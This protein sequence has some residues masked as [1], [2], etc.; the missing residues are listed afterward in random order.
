MKTVSDSGDNITLMYSESE[1]KHYIEKAN[2]NYSD[3]H[4]NLYVCK[5]YFKVKDS[6][7]DDAFKISVTKG[8]GEIIGVN[9][10]SILLGVYFYLYRLGFRFPAPDKSFDLIPVIDDFEKLSLN[11]EHYYPYRHRGICIE[12]AS[13]FENIISMIE[14][15]PKLGFNC[16]FSQFQI[17]YTFMDRWY[18]HIFNDKLKKE[19]FNIGIAEDYT[20]KIFHEIHLRKLSL[21]TSGHGWNAGIL[22]YKALGWEKMKAPKE[23]K[24][25]FIALINGKREFF[26]GVPL[27]TNLCYSDPDVVEALSEAV[28]D[29]CLEAKNVNYVHF[30]L[31][32]ESNNVCECDNCKLS[33]LSDQY[34]NIL[35][36]I[37]EKL[38]KHKLDTH[39][40]FLLYQELLWPPV[41]EK[42]K[43]NER[44][45][46]MFAPISR[47]FN[48]SYPDKP[49]EINV[50]K[51][52][53][54][55]I[56]LPDSVEENLSFLKLWQNEFKGDSFLYDYPLGR[57]HYG[58]L[59]YYHISKLIFNDIMKLNDLSLNG[60]IS[61]QEIRAGLPNYLPDYIMGYTLS[62][63]CK[64]F[65]E[66]VDDFYNSLY[67]EHSSLVREY[68]EELSRYSNCDYFNGKG[69]RTD[70]DMNSEFI[71]L[72]NVLESY[73]ERLNIADKAFDMLK[74]HNSYCIK[75]V[76]ALIALSMGDSK[77]ANDLFKD[78]KGF[79]S[80]NETKYQK[81]LDVYRI[82]E[83]STKYTGFNKD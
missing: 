51:Y 67:K 23:C 13:S 66:F 65:D 11:I 76:K 73:K 77:I 5:E 32:D 39:I 37:D 15:M 36:R 45:T 3:L 79:I 20:T 43:N 58:D 34:I 35:N 21:H 60:Y 68:L 8:R 25:S 28:V 82:I 83:V 26:N 41:K 1:L 57:A 72:L 40:V 74:Y 7:M 61:C 46:M 69:E 49:K 48:V 38:T 70:L 2:I 75:L 10:R 81:N 55:K 56:A 30:W 47:S 33:T 22:G 59:G 71:K 42:I 64:D 14:W 12:G 50:K 29:Y 6:S 19:E 27:N 80:D 9:E 4:I 44:F 16:F 62:G 24:T 17:P 52:V 54:N 18:N 78:F 63:I 31:A 53:R